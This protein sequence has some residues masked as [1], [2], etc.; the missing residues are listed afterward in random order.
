M[1]DDK[2]KTGRQDRSRVAAEQDYEVHDIADKFDI[3]PQAKR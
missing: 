2:T 1:A 3:S